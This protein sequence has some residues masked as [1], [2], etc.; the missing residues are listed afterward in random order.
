[1]S[2]RSRKWGLRLNDRNSQVL[3]I[4]RVWKDRQWFLGGKTINET[5]AYKYL[6]T[7]INRQSK[8]SE[9]IN[10]HLATKAKKLIY[11]LHAKHM[12]INR[13]H[14]GDTIWR[15]ALQPI[16]CSWGGV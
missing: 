2:L 9:H 7:I 4:G 12:D 5:K 13:I 14:F 11:A 1:M 8:D 16:T 6:C 15:T 10:D 3:I